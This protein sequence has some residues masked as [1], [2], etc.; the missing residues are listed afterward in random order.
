[1]TFQSINYTKG[2]ATSP[3]ERGNKIIAHVCNDLGGWGKGFVLAVSARW[4][5]PE[6]HYMFMTFNNI[7]LSVM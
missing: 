6:Q 3:A 7:G 4:S 2:D 1:M 5:E